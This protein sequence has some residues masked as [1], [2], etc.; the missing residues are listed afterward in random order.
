MS[1][2]TE[3]YAKAENLARCRLTHKLFGIWHKFF[4]RD[5]ITVGDELYIKLEVNITHPPF[6]L[7][8]VQF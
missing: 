8:C 1:N 2:R 3:S 7:V 6:L 5:N 4:V